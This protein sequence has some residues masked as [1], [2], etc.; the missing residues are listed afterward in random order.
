MEDALEIRR[1]ILTAFE[2]AEARDLRR[3]TPGMA[4]VRR[5]RGRSTGLELAG[6]IA[7]IARD[8]LRR[9]FRTIDPSDAVILLVEATGRV[10][11]AYDPR[12]SGKAA[13]AL[14]HLGVTLMLNTTVAD[15]TDGSSA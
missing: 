14:R 3:T 13:A 8:T 10:L 11:A 15:V 2:A 1:R 5:H 4:D 9:E 6:Q 7:E 12:L